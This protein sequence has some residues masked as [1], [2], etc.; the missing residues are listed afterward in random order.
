MLL[1][2]GSNRGIAKVLEEAE[3]KDS[4]EAGTILR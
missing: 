1:E 3:T 4:C 2:D